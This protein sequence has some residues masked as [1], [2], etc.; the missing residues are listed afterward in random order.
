MVY[1]LC[2]KMTEQALHLF[3]FAAL[4]AYL[5]GAAVPN[6]VLAAQCAAV[7]AAVNAGIGLAAVFAG[8]LFGPGFHKEIPSVSLRL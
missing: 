2:L 1:S 8:I 5:A 3:N 7:A 4:F 6:A